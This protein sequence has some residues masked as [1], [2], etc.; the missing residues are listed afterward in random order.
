MAT[1][2]SRSQGAPEQL[3]DARRV[4]L[5]RRGLH[6]LPH[7]E[8]EGVGLARSIL[9]DRVGVFFEHR[10]DE[11][12]DLCVVVYLRETFRADDLAGGPPRGDHLV[13]HVLRH[14]PADRALRD[15]HEQA[16][17]PRGREAVAQPRRIA[18]AGFV[19]L[20]A[21]GAEQ[22]VP[23]DLRVRA[24]GNR[25][26]EIRREPRARHRHDFGVR[27]TVRCLQPGAQLGRRFRQVV[28]R[29][30]EPRRL[31]HQRRQVRLWKIAVVVRLFLAAH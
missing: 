15:Q 7:E 11:A 22:P 3:V 31:E 4:R 25:V 29:V 10:R 13:E 2:V 5:P 9:R 21:D 27:E 6:H 26:L 8:A 28:L 1:S 18:A 23:R 30:L 17:Q 16:G 14:G 12:E 20:C 24:G 19:D